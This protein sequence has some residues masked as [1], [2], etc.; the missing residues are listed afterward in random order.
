VI[1]SFNDAGYLPEGI[2]DCTLDEAAMRFGTFQLNDQRP[3]LWARLT[4]F[5]D[6]AKRCEL[7]EAVLVDGSFVTSNPYPNDID[8]VVVVAAGHDFLTDLPP[9]RYN[10]LSQRR[11]RS[12]FGFDIVVVTND[13]E[14]L[15][16]AVDFFQQVKQR[17]GEKKG[18]LRISL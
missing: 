6:E 16:Q 3:R 15:E 17:P 7:I 9:V 18:I 10:L 5:V 8:L 13:S 4:E 12:R 2:H 14:K 11:V 1:P